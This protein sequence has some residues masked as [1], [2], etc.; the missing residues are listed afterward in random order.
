MALITSAH[1]KAVFLR[2]AGRTQEMVDDSCISARIPTTA[3][4]PRGVVIVH[5]KTL[6]RPAEKPFWLVF[7]V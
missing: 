3:G 7:V 6:D 4:V 2:E 1:C 5:L